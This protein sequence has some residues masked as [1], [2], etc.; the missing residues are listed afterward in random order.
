MKRIKYISIISL[1]IL[2]NLIFAENYYYDAIDGKSKG[3]LANDVMKLNLENKQTKKVLDDV[4]IPII[5]RDMSKVVFRA[6]PEQKICI[7]DT[8]TTEIDTV[9]FLGSCDRLISASLVPYESKEAIY[10]WVV[11]NSAGW[12]NKEKRIREQTKILVDKSSPEII[13]ST[14]HHTVNRYNVFSKNGMTNYFIKKDEN[15]IYFKSQNTNTGKIINERIP[16]KE[17]SDYNI[18][19]FEPGPKR[20]DKILFWFST[21]E[22]KGYDIYYNPEKRKIINKISGYAELNITPIDITNKN[23][24]IFMNEEVGEIYILE[25]ETSKLKKRI[26][27]FSDP[28]EVDDRYS[29]LLTL[30]DTLYFLPKDPEHHSVDPP[31]HFDKRVSADVTKKQSTSSL[32]SMLSQDVDNYTEK[33]WI[34]SQQTADDLK[35]KLN[36]EDLSGF[37]D[38]LDQEKGNTINE[39]AYQRLNFNSK[40]IKERT[41]PDTVTIESMIDEV[42]KYY[43]KGWIEYDWVKQLLIRHLEHA[44]TYLENDLTKS[45]QFTLKL[46][47]RYTKELNRTDHVNETAKTNLITDAQAIIDN[48]ESKTGAL[49][50][51]AGTQKDNGSVQ[52]MLRKDRNQIEQ[53]EKNGKIDQE[54]KQNLLELREK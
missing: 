43:Q 42:E 34:S 39:K 4:N 52:K 47:I 54:L 30:N 3:M 48:I 12:H 24:L 45:A 2:I 31:Y 23:D 49:A 26:K 27:L 13:D 15:G 5:M 38:I 22:G 35:E 7:Y 37:I 18:E 19:G 40:K 50:K 44:Q 9:D 29:V 41:E 46:F 8:E 1:L 32:I 51:S 53:L 28:K 33:G 20:D 11:K 10:I 17:L 6:I 14:A 16:I 21:T 25:K 36:Q